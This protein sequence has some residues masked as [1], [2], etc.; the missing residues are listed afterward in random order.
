MTGQGDQI[1][2]LRRELL[3]LRR[4]A[5]TLRTIAGAR[6]RQIKLFLQ[7]D[8]AIRS[9][10]A[11]Q[12]ARA[13]ARRKNATQARLIARTTGRQ[14]ADERQRLADLR[15]LEADERDRLADL[16]EQ[17]LDD[18]E[19]LADE[20]DQLADQRDRDANHRDLIA[21]QR[22]VATD[23]RDLVVFNRHLRMFRRRRRLIRPVPFDRM[24][25]AQLNG[26][27]SPHL[28]AGPATPIDSQSA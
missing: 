20:H 19:R 8:A 1:R 10:E 22:D 23:R 11:A 17:R 28:D 18:R 25:D 6:R 16:R 7:A 4:R 24:P 2:S 27:R 14:D 13:A 9:A 3:R 15:D 12:R 26:H 5:W 21:D